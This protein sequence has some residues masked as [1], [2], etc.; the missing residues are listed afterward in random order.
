MKEDIDGATHPPTQHETLE[1]AR[2][3]AKLRTFQKRCEITVFGDSKPV[4]AW[5]EGE[6]VPV[7]ESN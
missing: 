7:K 2:A 1:Q 5:R 4:E 6:L 3:Y